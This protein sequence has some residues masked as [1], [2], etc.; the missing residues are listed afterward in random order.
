[1][2]DNLLV[3]VLYRWSQA[4]KLPPLLALSP[5]ERWQAARTG[6]ATSEANPNVM[7]LILTAVLV[8]LVIVL[9]K[10]SLSSLKRDRLRH[11]RAFGESIHRL[12]LST[13]EHQLLLDVVRESGLRHRH[14][15]F[16]QK[17]AFDRGA[18]R[19]LAKLST[20]H[21][22]P[23][24]KQQLLAE[25][26]FLR[27]K[28]HL[29]RVDTPPLKGGSVDESESGTGTGKRRS[30]LTTRE[31]PL[32]KLLHITRRLDHQGDDFHGT[33]VANN[34]EQ[35]VLQIETP[36]KICFGEIWQAR[37]YFGASVW[38]FTTTVISYDG[39]RLVLKHSQN[40][41]FVNRRRFVRVAT[42]HVAYIAHYPFYHV[43][44][45][46]S[47]A[48]VQV[49]FTEAT[50][51]ELAGPGLRME[52]SL[53]AEP[54][55]RVLISFR[56]EIPNETDPARKECVI[57]TMGEVRRVEPMY[58]R[59]AMG[60]R[61]IGLKDGDID[62][63]VGLTNKAVYATPSRRAQEPVTERPEQIEGDEVLEMVCE[64]PGDGHA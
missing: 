58:D 27:D 6:N 29:T 53:S 20:K 17:A 15:I 26:G 5:T 36:V 37:Y 16:Q 47:K 42:K 38:E 12:N 41:R 56:L 10:V 43:K 2:I 49:D 50:V 45:S 19:L 34:A 3:T 4:W 24:S 21:N 60:I 62:Q 9:V 28:L 22:D 39:D 54:G 7:P 61:L 13:R 52:T 44:D 32:N 51:T 25:I 55:D 59:H 48:C 35:L 46:A 40:V 1:M 18:D 23:E 31:L 8:A 14:A 63:L 33:I 64:S 11:K 57:N 30:R